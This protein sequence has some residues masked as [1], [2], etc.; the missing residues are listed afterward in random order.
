MTSASGGRD[1]SGAVL[2]LALVFLVVIS[3]IVGALTEWIT[4]DLANSA[5]FTATQNVSNAATNAVNLAI[6]NIR[7][8]PL[9]YT[10]VNNTTTDLTL[11]ASPPSYCWGPGPRPSTSIRTRCRW[12]PP[13]NMNVYCTRSGT[14][15]RRTPAR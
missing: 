8:N 15:R 12:K 6:Q 10:S 7:Y 3:V 2:I 9:L 4:N 1:E 13:Y 11:N 14:R 5:N